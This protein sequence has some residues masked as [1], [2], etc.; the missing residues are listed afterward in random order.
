MLVCSD[1][2]SEEL[3]NLLIT[4][5]ADLNIKDDEDQTALMHAAEG[6]EVLMELLLEHNAE[7]D[8]LNS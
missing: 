2:G 4:K 8:H 3:I 7:F 5:G 6:Y 1:G